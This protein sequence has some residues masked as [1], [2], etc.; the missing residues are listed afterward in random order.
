VLLAALG[1][2]I[3]GNL[4]LGIT[5][6]TLARTQQQAQQLAQFSLLPQMMLSGFMFPFQ[7]MPAWA[8][9]VGELL[10]LTHILRIVRG[11]ML[12]GNGF[13]EIATDLWPLALFALVLG[14]AAVLCYRET[15][16]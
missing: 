4:A 12:K 9:G 11:I 3:A 6:S 16:D 15:L 1:V 2:F 10:P 13:A 8:R 7:G 14:V 5:F